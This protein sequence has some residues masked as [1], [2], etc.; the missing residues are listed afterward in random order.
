MDT[1][2]RSLD[3]AKY[4]LPEEIF[5]YFSLCQVEERAHELHFYFDE[6]NILPEA[7]CADDLESKGFHKE[8][9]I[10]DFPI[11]EKSLYL[12]VSRRRWLNKTTGKAVS[13][14]WQLVAEGTHYT[15]GFASFLKEIAGRSS[16]S[17][18]FT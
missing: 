12:H 8:C 14:A 2:N 1:P 6:K 17:I 10:K 3:L 4:I 15:Q 13:R 9:I 5:Q 16:D 18:Q 7:Y 11:R